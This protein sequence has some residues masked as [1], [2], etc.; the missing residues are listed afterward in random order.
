MRCF[1]KLSGK[2]AIRCVKVERGGKKDQP[3]LRNRVCERCFGWRGE[4]GSYKHKDIRN[5]IHAG[6]APVSPKD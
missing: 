2:N 6:P 4:K 3:F 1:L 5:F